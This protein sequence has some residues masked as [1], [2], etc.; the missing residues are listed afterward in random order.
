[1]LRK[2]AP[3]ASAMLC[4][5]VL[6]LGNSNST[7]AK[8]SDLPVQA[9][10]SIS[11]SLGL[12]MPQYHARKTHAGY[13]IENLRQGLTTQF[14]ATGVDTRA[15]HD[16]W[17][18]VLGSYG[19]GNKLCHVSRVFPVAEGNR[20]EYRHGVV[21]EWYVNG[22]L[23]LEQG[24]TIARR[25]GRATARLL[26][27]TLGLSGNLT[28]VAEDDNNLRLTASNGK[29]V[30]RYAGL[31]ARDANGK[32][33]PASIAVEN[34]SVSLKIDDSEGQYP[35]TIDPTIQHFMLTASDGANSDFFGDSV[36]ID[37]NT[38]VVGAPGHLG[39]MG[40]AYV[41]IKP[42]SGWK[43]MTQTAKLTALDGAR[44]DDFG[45]SV[46]ISGAIVVVGA[47]DASVDGNVA[48]GAAYVFVKPDGGWRDTTET[49]KLT[50]SD[51]VSDAQFGSSVS[52]SGNTLVVGAP[53]GG[54]GD[55][56]PGAAY[57]FVEPNGGWTNMTQTAELM[58]S[59]GTEEDD[60]GDSVSISGNVVIVGALNNGD[61]DTGAAYV[62]VEPQ[63]GWANMTQTAKLTPSDG[64]QGDVFGISV[65]VKGNT[66]VVGSTGESG[67]AYLYVKPANGWA[68]M[69]QTAKLTAGADGFGTSVSFDGQAVVVG[70]PETNPNHQGAAYV[71][72]EP[73]GGWKDTSKPTL[74]LS[75]SFS[76][77]WDFFGYSVGIS[78]KTAVVG[79]NTAPTSPPCKPFC[80][81]GPGE[82]FV[83]VEQ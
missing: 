50:A 10:S 74:T 37:G 5:S 11:A 21:T 82:A 65:S 36:A 59:D 55:P 41:F 62:F 15:G 39:A 67:G 70:A 78:G 30:L 57:I 52:L 24:F 32:E 45:V 31:T 7:K 69:T 83:F 8:L 47:G 79:A 68:N 63:T 3:C 28:A 71:F 40:E 17:K 14:T 23:G 75:I 4:L 61:S 35:V 81:P 34:D 43:N 20:I 29:P 66:A 58:A 1:M 60:F 18:M 9:Q 76:A 54:V 2:L 46:S 72:V 16:H 51:G 77:G 56:G 33:L 80:V 6:C 12:D 25:P 22:P 42:A 64:T 48:Q 73:S 53:A 27:L 26:R 44:G 13:A 19:Y 49:A 38:V